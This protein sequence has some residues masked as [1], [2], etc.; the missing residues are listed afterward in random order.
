MQIWIIESYESFCNVYKYIDIHDLA[1]LRAV[2]S[3]YFLF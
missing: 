2:W 3:N 1:R